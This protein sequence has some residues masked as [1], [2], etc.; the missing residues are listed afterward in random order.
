M[1]KSR[2]C[3][4]DYIIKN[5]FGFTAERSI[6]EAIQTIRIFMEKHRIKENLYLVFIELVKAFDRVSRGLVWQALQT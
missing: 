3:V 5:Q 2:R 1:G 6:I 4:S